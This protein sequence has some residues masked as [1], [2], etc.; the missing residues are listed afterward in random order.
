MLED[1]RFL[2]GADARWMV[3]NTTCTRTAIAALLGISRVTLDKYLADGGMD[4][5]YLAE[6]RRVQKEQGVEL[7]SCEN[8]PIAG[9]PWEKPAVPAGEHDVNL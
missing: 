7:Y 5:A 1:Q 2:R 8:L 3:R 6:V 9:I 4:D